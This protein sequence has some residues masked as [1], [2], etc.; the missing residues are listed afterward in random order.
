[1]SLL[2]ALFT[3]FIGFCALLLFSSSAHRSIRYTAL[4]ISL[5]G[6]VFA[7]AA[8]LGFDYQSPHYQYMIHQ[9]WIGKFDIGFRI[10]VDGMS[11]LFVLLTAITM[12]VV[13]LASFQTILERQKHWYAMILL[14]QGSV[15]GC[16]V[17]LDTVLFYTFFELLLIP[18]YFM[19]GIWG[20]ERKI[21][22][23]L[24]FF[25]YTMFGSMLL[26]V[27]LVWLSMYVQEQTGQF[28]TNWLVL[29]EFAPTIPLETQRW[30]FWAAV[31]AF[32]I[33]IPLFPLHTWLPDVQKEAPPAGAVVVGAVL[34]KIG[35]YGLIRFVLELFPA[36]SFEYATVIC[37]FAAVAVVYGGLLTIVQT[38]IKR[39]AAYALVCSLGVVVMGIFSMT[40]EGLQGAI[41]QTFNHGL[42]V[43]ALFLCI[44]FVTE[45]RKTTHLADFGGLAKVMPVFTVFFSLSILSLIGLPGLNGFVGE[46][47]LMLGTFRSPF[48]Q[49][50][51][52][53]IVAASAGTLAA[54][55]LLKMLQNVCFGANDRVENQELRD[56][57]PL[58][59]AQLVPAT[60]LMIW[61]GVYPASF[62]KYSEESTKL[63]V[64]RL[65]V[66]R[67]GKTNVA[68][69][70]ITPATSKTPDAT[71][72]SSGH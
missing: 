11:I 22:A 45:R 68:G 62:M 51:V 19:I 4:S 6:F 33:K 43:A 26:L 56:V 52:F 39:M 18:M 67:F 12:P 42:S 20:G 41:I 25:I 46:Y 65:E 50:W 10:G 38:D 8:F 27:A 16:F 61:I 63:L 59:I 36:A 40:P 9:P 71:P 44:G 5:L 64:S 31:L 35:V 54:V 13:V 24:K 58:E 2:F 60:V 14:L 34:F 48:L 70:A 21:Y 49:T 55:Y 69:T 37:W 1:M 15:T 72:K 28:S 30:L 66:L 53:G 29:Q 32:C 23:A 17:A 47:L 7:L 3:P 57:S